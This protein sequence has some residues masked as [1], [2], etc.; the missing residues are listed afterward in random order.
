MAYTLIKVYHYHLINHVIV[1]PGDVASIASYSAPW[2]PAIGFIV[3][4]VRSLWAKAR[5][6]GRVLHLGMLDAS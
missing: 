4:A 3:Q 2:T 5:W 1:K 6:S